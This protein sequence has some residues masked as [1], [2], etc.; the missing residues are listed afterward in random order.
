MHP[1]RRLDEG[2]NAFTLSFDPLL[3]D[4]IKASYLR[5]LGP[6]WRDPAHQ[7]LLNGGR[8]IRQPAGSEYY[9]FSYGEY[10][11]LWFSSHTPGT[12]A[13]YRRLF[14]A[15]QL[16]ERFKPLIDHEQGIQIYCGFLVIGDRADEPLWH[17]DYP[18]GTPAYTLIT[19][20]F[21]PEPEHG[22]LLYFRAQD[23]KLATY[24]Y[25]PG[26]AIILGEDFLHSTEPYT[27][28]GKLR[29]LVSLTFGTDKW[30]H[31]NQLKTA[32]TTQS[33]YYLQPCGHAVGT[34]RC[35]LRQR[36]GTIFTR[37]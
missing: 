12:F 21:I 10:P 17:V 35:R 3:L 19:P 4:E 31:W 25:Q 24:S 27:S 16:G 2:L 33:K 36:I 11:L 15:L 23:R 37:P 6:F 18:P 26:E 5:E 1:L 14:E 34:C 30:Q 32:V 8:N 20:L 28:Q 7:A 29:V 13:L 9:I 22:H